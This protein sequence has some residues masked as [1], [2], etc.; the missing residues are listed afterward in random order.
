MYIAGAF[1]ALSLSATALLFF[2]RVRAVY[3]NSKFVTA[4]FGGLWALMFGCSFLVPFGM[5]SAPIGK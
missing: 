3:S 5:H 4:F 2:F 1:Y